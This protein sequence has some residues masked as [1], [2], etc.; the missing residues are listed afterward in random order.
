MTSLKGCSLGRRGRS[1]RSCTSSKG[2]ALF[3]RSGRMQTRAGSG[4]TTTSRRRVVIDFGR[5]RRNGRQSTTWSCDW[6]GGVMSKTEKTFQISP[7]VRGEMQSISRRAT[8]NQGVDPRVAEELYGH[9][10]DKLIGYLA[11]DE[12]LTEADAL[13]LVREHFGNPEALRPILA[14]ANLDD[15][16]AEGGPPLWRKLA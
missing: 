4:N 7:A 11:G 10:E 13:I 3:G 12:R 6:R 1:I 14:Y 16:A 9:L 5:A 15:A 8:E 2:Q